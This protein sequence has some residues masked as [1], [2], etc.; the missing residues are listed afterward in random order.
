MVVVVVLMSAWP[1]KSQFLPSD[2]FFIVRPTDP[3]PSNIHTNCF[4]DIVFMTACLTWTDPFAVLAPNAIKLRRPYARYTLVVTS[5]LGGSLTIPTIIG[6]EITLNQAS[7]P[8]LIAP[9][10]T[11]TF[12]VAGQQLDN[13]AALSQFSP[14]P[15]ILIFPTANITTVTLPP[16]PLTTNGIG[17][18]RIGYN[19]ATS[20]V[21]ASW[22]LGTR[23]VTKF[24]LNVYC[25]RADTSLPKVNADGG[26]KSSTATSLSVPWTR[27]GQFYCKGVLNALYTSG[28]SKDFRRDF[29]FTAS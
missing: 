13:P 19:A 16:N 17:R 26:I 14:I 12:K 3:A 10:A 6:N 27:K 2:P 15:L 1:A 5:S 11:V 22:T 18:V 7:A 24:T 25:F 28:A 23:A 4:P 21:V 8:N 9:G 20:S 29:N